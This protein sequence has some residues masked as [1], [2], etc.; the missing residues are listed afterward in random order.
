MLL[1]AARSRIR[2]A[3]QSRHNAGFSALFKQTDGIYITKEL[4]ATEFVAGRGNIG[5][6]IVSKS[7]RCEIFRQALGI[8]AGLPK[9][10]MLN[11]IGPRSSERQLFERLVTRL[12]RTMAE[13]RSHAVII[14][15]EGKDY[16]HVVRRMGIYN[17]VPSRYGKWPGGLTYKNMPVERLVEDIVYRDSRNSPFIQMADFCAYA[18]FRSEYPLASKT[19]YGLDKAFEVLAPICVAA[20]SESDPRG[21]GIIRVPH[22]NS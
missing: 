19:K 21:L 16:S 1:C 6:D 3:D 20:A 15:D 12:N 4:H 14:H 7:R 2:L 10:R 11:A 17:P 22:R 13:W 5:P 18:L 9:I 8:C